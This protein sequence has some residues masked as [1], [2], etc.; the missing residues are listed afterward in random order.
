MIKR[1]IQKKKEKELRRK[2]VKFDLE[3]L[4]LD[5][6]RKALEHSMSRT[7]ITLHHYNIGIGVRG[8]IYHD[9][10]LYDYTIYHQNITDSTYVIERW[11]K[12]NGYVYR[13][14]RYFHYNVIEVDLIKTRK[15]IIKTERKG[16]KNGRN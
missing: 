4:C 1:L 3:L 10:T 5:D 2:Q 6:L 12:Q 15:N 8:G 9:I 14:I 7:D 13:S 11:L 16:L